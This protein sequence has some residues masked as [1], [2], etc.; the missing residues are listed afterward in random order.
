VDSD[1]EHLRAHYVAYYASIQPVHQ[2][3][4]WNATSKPHP[5]IPGGR[6]TH[7]LYSHSCDR[8]QSTVNGQTIQISAVNSQ[9]GVG[10]RWNPSVERTRLVLQFAPNL[11]VGLHM[12]EHLFPNI[13]ARG[14]GLQFKYREFF[15][16]KIS[17]PS[18]VNGQKLVWST[19][20]LS[21]R[22]GQSFDP[23][24]QLWL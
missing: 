9:S 10:Q 6:H 12:P 11:A 19:V 16:G 8:T 3:P 13:Q 5:L 17:E 7:R 23:R 22:A 24:S 15:V 1:T 14:L 18:K 2:Q 21:K 4:R 20:K